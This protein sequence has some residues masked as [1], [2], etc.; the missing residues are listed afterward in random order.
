MCGHT[1][2]FGHPFTVN[3]YICCLKSCSW[4]NCFLNANPY[5]WSLEELVN[6]TKWAFLNYVP[7]VASEE[8]TKPAQLWFCTNVSIIL[9]GSREIIRFW[10]WT[11]LTP[12]GYYS[13]LELHWLKEYYISAHIIIH[14]AFCIEFFTRFY[15]YSLK[16]F[17]FFKF[18]TSEEMV[19]VI[20]L[21]RVV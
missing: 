4:C 15:H 19:K 2:L 18:Q 7:S 3:T 1:L 14:L 11:F 12:T 13:L 16:P 21:P 17:F 20:L 6:F 5:V 9:I 8:R 10:A